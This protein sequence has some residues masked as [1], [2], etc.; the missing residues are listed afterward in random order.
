MMIGV[1]GYYA[2]ITWRCVESSISFPCESH[3]WLFSWHGM[4]VEHYH[5]SEHT[6]AL[7]LQD[8]AHLQ[9]SWA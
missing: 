1:C 8:S 6:C 4:G 2:R 3:R 9:G 5:G 7:L